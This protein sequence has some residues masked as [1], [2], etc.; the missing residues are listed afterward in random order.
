MIWCHDGLMAF[1]CI[2]VRRDGA[3]AHVTL[4]RPAVRNAFNEQ[5]IAD[6][7]AWA[8]S[9]GGDR[10]LRAAVIAGAGPAFCAGADLEWMARS[11]SLSKE[12]NVRDAAAAARMFHALDSL[13]FPVIGR[14]HGAAL[15]GGVGLVAV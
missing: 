4:N 5:I 8:E 7:T 15:G 13:P 10:S 9:A 1:E 2:T 12:D 14:V 6:V 11:V 3:V